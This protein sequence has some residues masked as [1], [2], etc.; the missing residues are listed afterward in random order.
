MLTSSFIFD[1]DFFAKLSNSLTFA[2]VTRFQWTRN[3]DKASFDL[4]VDLNNE[5]NIRTVFGLL[6]DRSLSVEKTDQK[7]FK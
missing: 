6:L 1:F 7:D 4:I 5:K 3:N 2:K